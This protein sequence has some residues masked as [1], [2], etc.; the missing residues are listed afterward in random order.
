MIRMLRCVTRRACSKQFSLQ[1]QW[2]F[3]YVLLGL[4]AAKEKTTEIVEMRHFFLYRQ[5]PVCDW[6]AK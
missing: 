2:A 4:E 6:P 1:F 5:V 3:K